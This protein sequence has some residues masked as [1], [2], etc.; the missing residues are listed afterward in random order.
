VD[1]ELRL[2]SDTETVPL[3]R[4]FVTTKLG[5]L[6]PAE[7]VADAEVAVSELVTNAVLH[8]GTQVVVRLHVTSASVR[9]EVED[10]SHVTPIRPITSAQ[11][12]TGRGLALVERLSRE[13]GVDR[14]KTGKVVWCVLPC[15][16]AKTARRQH[17]QDLVEDELV[18]AILDT[19]EPSGHTRNEPVF[20]VSL[21]DVPTDLLLAAEEHMDNL[22]REFALAATGASS[23]EATAMPADMAT[24]VDTVLHEF[25][26]P[27]QA[28]KV[29]ALAAADRREERTT[30]TLNL[31]LSA[32]RG[33]EAYLEALDRADAYARGARILTLETPPQHRAFRRWYLETIVEQLQYAATG[34]IPKIQ[35]TFEQYL[36][37]A[38]D[39]VSAAQAEAEGLASRLGHLQQLTAELTAVSEVDDIASIMVGHAADAFGAQYA[40]LYVRD[41]DELTAVR[42]RGTPDAFD[43]LWRRVRLDAALPICEAVRRS[44]P[45]V[46]RG[47][48]EIGRRYPALTAQPISDVSVACVPLRVGE[49]CIGVVA[50]TFPLYRH[51]ED[52]AEMA[53]LS[54]LADACAQALDRVRALA[55]ARATADKLS[56]LAEASSI[57]SAS[58]DANTALTRLT[59][60]VVP[61]LADWC[62][63][64]TVNG[65][66]LESVAVTHVD[67]NKVRMAQDWQ[68]LYPSGLDD[69]TASA[70]VVR[71]GT[72][73]L[74]REI[75]VEMLDTSGAIPE[76]VS[77]AAE[78]GLRSGLVVPLTGPGGTFGT[79]TLLYAESDRRYDDDDL[80]LATEIASRAA[81]AVDRARRYDLQTGQLARITRIAETAQH[82]I[83]A[84]VPARMGSVRLAATYVSAAREALIGGD[85]YEAV[86]ARGC[87]R[88]LIGD[89]RGKGLDAVRLA[90]VVLGFFRTAAVESRNLARLARQLDARLR[91]YLGEEDF[92]TALM[93]E[94]AP[95]GACSLV[96]CGHPNPLLARGGYLGEVACEPSTPLGLDAHPVPSE[97]ELREGDRLLLF[98]DGLIEARGPRGDYPDLIQL[99][100]PLRRGHLG[101]GLRGILAR[102]R[103]ATGGELGDDLALLAAEYA[104]QAEPVT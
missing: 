84:P 31:P 29:Q 93:L 64:Q 11:S 61:R 16:A 55:E 3:A 99:A 79:I 69:D 59:E 34:G 67:P 62:A 52:P 57:L 38:L 12:M 53:F 101:S 95:D 32:I 89:V 92:V 51:L 2:P 97:F 58:L 103:A 37:R 50:L 39:Q 60:L 26:G 33:A 25:S 76:Q 35:E 96:S 40:A 102:L 66:Q 81:L 88:L 54:S 100:L 15:D 41:D 80:L 94:I 8:A 4:H 78:L 63:I 49:R 82:A 14:T 28:I 44:R 23:G 68:Q 91:P 21:G 90:T 43:E 7:V 86:D 20:T 71:T 46:M 30:L 10:D 73:E 45:I 48:T 74:F 98:T 70:R 72:P 56:F 104:P 13:L 36:L 65:D 24:M 75:S 27:R 9:I 1:H 18:G 83:L 19:W 42:T 77:M 22:G 5:G 85:L 87:V 17:T 6:L 47:A